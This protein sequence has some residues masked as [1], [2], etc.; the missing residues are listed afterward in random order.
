VLA[1]VGGDDGG[2]GESA[3]V[4]RL[5]GVRWA[6]ARDGRQ[7]DQE[8]GAHQGDDAPSRTEAPTGAD[9]ASPYWAFGQEAGG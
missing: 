3:D 7:Q 1:S 6:E 4:A 2:R 9:D 8:P 5:E